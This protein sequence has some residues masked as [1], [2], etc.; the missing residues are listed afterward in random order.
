MGYMGTS[1]RPE[2]HHR[3]LGKSS[4]GPATNNQKMM[5]ETTRLTRK[6]HG[7]PIRNRSRNGPATAGPGRV[8]D[9]S[10]RNGDVK[11]LAK[12]SSKAS[13]R[14]NKIPMATIGVCTSILI[15]VVMEDARGRGAPMGVEDPM[16]ISGPRLRIQVSR[17]AVGTTAADC[18]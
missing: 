16:L 17:L 14:S 6:P 2:S 8:S 18:L 5:R 12:T 1:R 15:L 13:S 4:N 10:D 3:H 11:R 7:T 9:Q